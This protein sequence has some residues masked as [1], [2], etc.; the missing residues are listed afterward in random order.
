MIMMPLESTRRTI[1]LLQEC[2]TWDLMALI[3]ITMVKSVLT[4]WS[5]TSVHTVHTCKRFTSVKAK[6]T[7]KVQNMLVKHVVKKRKKIT[8]TT[9]SFKHATRRS[10]KKRL[11][12]SKVKNAQ[13]LQQPQPSSSIRTRQPKLKRKWPRRV[14]THAV[15]IALTIL[16]TLCMKHV[17]LKW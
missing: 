12:P 5:S 13:V 9:L 6:L 1:G 14:M 15:K 11:F 4:N 17:L 3:V 10:N 8:P 2:S 16:T 7:V